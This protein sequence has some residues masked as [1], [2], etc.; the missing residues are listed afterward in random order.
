MIPSVDHYWL[1]NA[2]VPV[3]LLQ[4]DHPEQFL[5][6]GDRF[7]ATL[8][9]DLAQVDLEIQAG[10]ITRLVPSGTAHPG[11]VPVVD[12]RRGQVWPCLV[13]MHTHLD[14]GHIWN[15]TP[16]RDRTFDGALAATQEDQKQYWQAEDVYRRM[17]F[18]L[19]CSYAHGTKA[20]R[21]HL[22]SWG[23]QA[24]IS[25]EVFKALR[26][27]W[28]DRLDLQAVSLVSLDYFRTPDGEKLAD[29]VAEVGGGVLGGLTLMGEDLDTELDRVFALAQ[30]RNLNL[31][32]HTDE[33][34]DPHAITLRHIAAA[35]IR[36]QFEGQVV[37]G[38]C[39]S[40]AVQDEDQV[41]K[42]LDLLKAAQIGVVSLPLCNLYLQDRNQQASKH[43]Q[44]AALAAAAPLAPGWTPRWRGVT[45]LHE[46]K[47]HGIPVT[48]ASDNCRDPFHG[49]GDHDVLEVFNWSVRIAHLDAPYADW[50]QAVTATAADLLKLPT[51]GRIGVGLPADLVLF[52]G[53]S[54]SELLARSQQDR[55]VLRQGRPIDTT[56]PDYAELD[57]L[58]QRRADL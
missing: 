45:L 55:I 33:S 21:T 40:L 28:G 19:Q 27:E 14:K 20:I 36:N 22:D 8:G 26:Q 47:A 35:A 54:F 50:P 41:S 12:R 48:V 13:D 23:E 32:F 58:I 18:G 9:E 53:R 7:S 24:Q 57:D 2:Q 11:D 56:L 25:F 51:V 30:E 38:H 39:C 29:L 42:T 31:D 43:F 34:G 3:S 44:Q 4:V 46:L 5:G 16:N 6:R 37:C 1:T 17:A 52:K 15:R 49:F 10:Q